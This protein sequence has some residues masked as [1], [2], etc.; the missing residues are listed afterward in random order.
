MSEEAS[1]RKEALAS[2]RDVAQRLGL[3]RREA[4]VM[5][6]AHNTLVLFPKA[7]VVAKV[8]TSTLDTRGE[9]PSGESF[10]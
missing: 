1:R 6:D 10:P 2:A 9:K 5:R 8:S 3:E 7:G 4:R